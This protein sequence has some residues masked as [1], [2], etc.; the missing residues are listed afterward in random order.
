MKFARIDDAT[1]AD[2]AAECLA[3]SRDLK[4]QRRS[5]WVRHSSGHAGDAPA[6]AGASLADSAAVAGVSHVDAPAD[7]G[8]S[9]ANP[10]TPPQDVAEPIGD[11][12][13][14]DGASGTRRAIEIEP[15]HALGNGVFGSC[16][17]ARDRDTGETAC[18]KLARTKDLGESA[19]IAI[20]TEFA[21]MGKLGHPNIMTAICLV[22][23]SGGELVGV[24][25]PLMSGS[26]KAWLSTAPGHAPA[27]AGGGGP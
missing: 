23:D 22:H 16:H 7:A 27:V 10:P 8:A 17:L 1:R 2:I 18:L 14:V 4:D 15:A 19:R 25:M 11:F 13:W 9:P 6:V 5:A 24:L 20:R 26:L 21:A 3:R 12:N